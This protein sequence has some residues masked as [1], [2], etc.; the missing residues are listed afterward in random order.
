[1][2]IVFLLFVL[3][4]VSIAMGI[5]I[6]NDVDGFGAPASPDCTYPELD[7]DNDDDHTFP[8]SD[9]MLIPT[10]GHFFSVMEHIIYLMAL[11]FD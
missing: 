8:P 5:C 10:I 11:K 1:M 4:D 7:C 9:G 6:D 2:V 3:L